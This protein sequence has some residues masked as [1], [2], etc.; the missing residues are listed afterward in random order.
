MLLAA[1]GTITAVAGGRVATPDIDLATLGEMLQAA[2]A[3]LAVVAAVLCFVRWRLVGDAPEAWVGAAFMCYA[4]LTVMAGGLLPLLRTDVQTTA[5]VS[6]LRSASLLVVFACLAWALLIPE[7][8][9]RTRPLLITLSAVAT[10]LMLAALLRYLAPPAELVVG[11][12]GVP[13]DPLGP[14]FP[15]ALIGGWLLLGTAYTL[16]GIR[17]ERWLF[18]WFGLTFFGLTFAELARWV[19]VRLAELVWFTGSRILV[20]VSLL[21]A[22]AGALRELQRAF[23]DQSARLL[24]SL[25]ASLAHESRLQAEQAARQERV[26]E[27]RNAL[28][29]IDGATQV[30]EFHRERLDSETR[31]R[32]ADSV[33]SEITRLQR[34]IADERGEGT[35]G[36]FGIQ[37][38]LHP[39]LALARAAGA[40]IEEDIPDDL[41]AVGRPA[42]VAEAVQ[43][44]LENARRYAPGS[45]VAVRAER[46]GEVVFL[47]TEDRGPGVPAADRER[48]FERGVRGHGVANGGEGLGLYVSRQLVEEQGGALWVEDRPGGGASFVL[49]LPAEELSDGVRPLLV[50][51]GIG[52]QRG[53]DPADGRDQILDADDGDRLLAPRGRDAP[54]PG[55]GVIG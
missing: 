18:A 55:P 4:T 6:P 42:D 50:E 38:A 13:A 16:R 40:L 32:L 54:G 23:A 51:A 31:G 12:T 14:L 20:V 45:P 37:E 15:L 29:A 30:L 1:G 35:R 17:E 33:S 48:I 3:A 2:T 26:H 24:E 27:A 53:G 44:M 10:T 8:S 36:R 46:L 22:V 39:V 28:T 25:V 49:A 21:C 11:P 47:R 9:T 7:V 41:E 43:N 19:T 5:V 52:P 34:I